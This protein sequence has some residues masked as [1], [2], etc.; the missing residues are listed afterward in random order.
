MTP[1]RV[2]ASRPVTAK[3]KD[4][5][6]PAAV[7]L[8]EAVGLAPEPLEK[9]ALAVRGTTT[10]CSTYVVVPEPGLDPEPEPEL[11]VGEAPE[12]VVDGDGSEATR[13]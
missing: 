9:S 1:P 12:P 2:V 8:P 6:M 3:M 7:F 11:V 10:W 5:A 4:G 13:N